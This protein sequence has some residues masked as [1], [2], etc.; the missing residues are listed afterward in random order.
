MISKI[1]YIVLL[2]LLACNYSFSQTPSLSVTAKDKGDSIA[3]SVKNNLQSDT[4]LFSLYGQIMTNK[5]WMTNNYDIFC[6]VKNPNTSVFIINPNEQITLM[7]AWP[8]GFYSN[9]NIKTGK[10]ICRQCIRIILIGNSKNNEA[11]EYKAF[12]NK[13]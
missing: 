8:I 4:V 5:K 6:N 2:L 13:L 1:F 11:I 10:S 7:A 3:V 12:S 9:R